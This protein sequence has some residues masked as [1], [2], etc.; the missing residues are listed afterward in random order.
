MKTQTMKEA[1]AE[2]AA[3]QIVLK[4]HRKTENFKG[5]E[6]KY[7]PWEATWKHAANRET[8][9]AMYVAYGILRGKELDQIE[10]N[11]K[12]EPNMFLVNKLVEKYQSEFKSDEDA[13][14]EAA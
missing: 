3:E 10:P 6:R 11:H 7:Q 4:A 8:L 13:V 9:R 2:M 5:T 14:K 12:T 1:I